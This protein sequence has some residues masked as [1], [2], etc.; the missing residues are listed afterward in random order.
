MEAWKDLL[1]RENG[2]LHQTRAFPKAGLIWGGL[3]GRGNGMLNSTGDTMTG[4]I[5]VLKQSITTGT[6]KLT[7]RWTVE[8]WPEPLRDFFHRDMIW[9]EILPENSSED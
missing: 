1:S 2:D 6:R 8:Y 7:A 3:H 9:H 5:K 4:G